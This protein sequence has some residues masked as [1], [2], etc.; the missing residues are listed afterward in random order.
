M[1][2]ETSNR[3]DAHGF[4]NKQSLVLSKEYVA[5]SDG[6]VIATINYNKNNNNQMVSIHVNRNMVATINASINNSQTISTF[7]KKGMTYKID[8]LSET[9]TIEGRFLPIC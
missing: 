1:V 7:V 9:T 6:Y 8:K 5:T 4:G 2:Q 3:L